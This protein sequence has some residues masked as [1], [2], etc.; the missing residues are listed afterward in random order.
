VGGGYHLPR[1]PWA[2]PFKAGEDGTV[3]EVIDKYE[4]YLF[5]ERPDLVA[6]LPELRGKTLACW[7]KPGPCHGDVLP[8]LAETLDTDP[9]EP[10]E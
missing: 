5:G 9:A 7:C 6:R 8:N 3:E 1:S 2:N 10:V 4:R